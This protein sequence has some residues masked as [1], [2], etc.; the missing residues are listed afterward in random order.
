MST[1]T[2]ANENEVQWIRRTADHTKARN[3]SLQDSRVLEEWCNTANSVEVMQ[4][5]YYAAV[6]GHVH[7]QNAF[8]ALYNVVN[9]S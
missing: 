8:V 4:K 6:Q 7:K 3:P 9:V 1:D 5:K 2:K